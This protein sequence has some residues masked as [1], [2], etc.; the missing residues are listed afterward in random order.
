MRCF[1]GLFLLFNAIADDI[2]LASVFTHLFF[3][4]SAMIDILIKKKG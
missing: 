2:L 4:L 3:L 1:D